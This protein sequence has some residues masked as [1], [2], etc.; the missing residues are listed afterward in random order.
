[1]PF[2]FFCCCVCQLTVQCNKDEAGIKFNGSIQVPLVQSNTFDELNVLSPTRRIKILGPQKVFIKTSSGGK[3]M[4]KSVKNLYYRS[5][6]NSV[7]ISK[8]LF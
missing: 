3:L 8:I 7:S 1:M 5:K 2:L 6:E 4:S